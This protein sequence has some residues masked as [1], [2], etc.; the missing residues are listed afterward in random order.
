[1]YIKTQNNLLINCDKV[2]YF[3]SCSYYSDAEGVYDY[4]EAVIDSNHIKIYEGK[5]IDVRDAFNEIS[6][7]LIRGA[8]LIDYSRIGD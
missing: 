4:I 5:E 8:S 1:M 3:K 2:S 6:M 7:G